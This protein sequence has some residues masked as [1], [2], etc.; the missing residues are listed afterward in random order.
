VSERVPTSLGFEVSVRCFMLQPMG[1]MSEIASTFCGH[2]PYR[3]HYRVG[4]CLVRNKRCDPHVYS[5]LPHS[6]GRYG[7]YIFVLCPQVELS[8]SLGTTS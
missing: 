6:D 4:E 2:I 8:P 7:P 1:T 3:C 5:N